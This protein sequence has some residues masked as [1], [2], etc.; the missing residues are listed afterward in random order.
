MGF[1]LDLRLANSLIISLKSN[2]LVISLSFAS[3]DKPLSLFSESD[4]LMRLFILFRKEN[5]RSLEQFEMG[6]ESII[7]KAISTLGKVCS[8]FNKFQILCGLQVLCNKFIKHQKFIWKFF[9]YVF[10]VNFLKFF[11]VFFN[12]HL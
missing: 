1:F 5:D 4:D 10:R 11:S 12:I 6:I 7:L 3:K 8:M 2:F 9:F